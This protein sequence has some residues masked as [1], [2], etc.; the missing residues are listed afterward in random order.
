[1]RSARGTSRPA[2]SLGSLSAFWLRSVA[3]AYSCF[4]FV[5]F[6]CFVVNQFRPQMVRPPSSAIVFPPPLFPLSPF[7]L[8]LSRSPLRQQVTVLRLTLNRNLNPISACQLF[9]FQILAVTRSPLPAR[10]SPLAA[11]RSDNRFQVSVLQLLPMLRGP[12]SFFSFRIACR[13]ALLREQLFS[14]SGFSVSAFKESPPSSDGPPSSFLRPFSPFPLF[15][16][17]PS[18]FY[19]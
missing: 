12:W 10:C 3:S 18:S 2:T 5:Y 4:V 1:M 17:S 9:R 6:V 11:P 19:S 14:V 13:N 15:T 8:F 16:S 7:P